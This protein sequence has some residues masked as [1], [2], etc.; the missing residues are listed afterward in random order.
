GDHG[1]RGEILCGVVRELRVDARI[2]H[3][4]GRY[5]QQRVAVRRRFGGDRG[6]NR[7][8]STAAIVDHDRL[9]EALVQLLP[10]HT[11]DDVGTAA[12]GV[13]HDEPDRSGGK[14]FGRAGVRARERRG[15]A[16]EEHDEI[17]P[18]HGSP[19]LSTIAKSQKAYHITP[20]PSGRKHRLYRVVTA[21][22]SKR[23][24]RTGTLRRQR[25]PGELHEISPPPTGPA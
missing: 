21:Q 10:E 1:Y 19:Q 9:A 17:S 7:A 5:Q 4:A 8:A 14:R 11:A 24:R 12:R 2:D 23:L 20:F 25:Q 18:S 3:V 16:A 22:P 15:A 13:G 6:A